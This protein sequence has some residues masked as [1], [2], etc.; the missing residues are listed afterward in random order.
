M[1]TDIETSISDRSE[2]ALTA[3]LS[4]LDA[5]ES[6]DEFVEI[7]Q[8]S[9]EIFQLSHYYFSSDVN[10]L[11]DFTSGSTT[12]R[13]AADYLDAVFFAGRK[14]LSRSD[15]LPHGPF[16]LSDFSDRNADFHCNEPVDSFMRSLGLKSVF[17][18]PIRTGS[19]SSFLFA[20]DEDGGGNTLE[21][22]AI[23][24]ICLSTVW[25]VQ[26][27]QS[28]PHPSTD[29]LTGREQFLLRDM[30][31]GLRHDDIAGS[32]GISTFALSAFENQIVKKLGAKNIRHAICLTR[33]GPKC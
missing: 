33:N 29:L 21:L 10:G 2:I 9:F 18:V 31:K 3:V 13:K 28:R 1:K 26:Q 15:G 12:A 8:S 30:A 20:L 25:R 6:I 5:A 23:Q 4:R 24:A 14:G 32:H 17:V 7:L 11:P 19:D 27:L 16:K 22:L